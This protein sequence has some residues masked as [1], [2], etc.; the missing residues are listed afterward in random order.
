MVIDRNETQLCT[1]EQLRA[2]LGGTGESPVP[3][4]R[5]RGGCYSYLQAVLKGFTYPRLK[6]AD[7]GGCCALMTEFTAHP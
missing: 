4:R 7:K 6:G 1:L 3:L 5:E 2:F